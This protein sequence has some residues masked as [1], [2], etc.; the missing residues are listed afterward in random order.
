MK[1][2]EDPT[3]R[4]ERLLMRAPVQRPNQSWNL[5][6]CTELT[7]TGTKT[8]KK[9]RFTTDLLE[10]STGRQNPLA[11]ETESEVGCESRAG[12]KTRSRPPSPN[13]RPHASAPVDP[14][15]ERD[16]EMCAGSGRR[17]R[18]SLLEMKNE[19]ETSHTRWRRNIGENQTGQL[20]PREN[21]NR[22]TSSTQDVK[23][24]LHRVP[25]YNRSMEFTALPLSFNWK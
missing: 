15:P 8:N 9:R 17:G 13:R 21:W 2:G 5:S 22:Q 10:L 11:R 16:K 1:P 23:L 19:S 12:N 6:V 7:A 4:P 24:S 25:N 20:R 3:K 18:S 14:K